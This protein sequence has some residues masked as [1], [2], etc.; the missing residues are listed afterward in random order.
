MNNIYGNWATLLLPLREDESID[1]LLLER[2]VSHLIGAKVNGIYSNGTAGEFYTLTPAE[3]ASTAE[4]LA[5]MCTA[6]GM[7]FQI[8]ASH[9]SAQTML[10]RIRIARQY[11]P[12]AIQVIL[13]DWLPVTN[14]EAVI[15]L[16]RAAET[17]GDI[18]LVV[19]NPPHA[20]RV[21]KPEDW[22]VLLDAVPQIAS[23][24]V[25]DGDEAWYEA[26]KP[27]LER[28]AVFVPGHHLATGFIRGAKGAYSNVAC[29][30]PVKAQRWYELMKTDPQAA[31][32][33]ERNVQAFM[34]AHISPLASR[35]GHHG[36]ALD[37]YMAT[38]GGWCDITPRIRFPY[39]SVP[40]TRLEEDRAALL[41]MAPY[42]ADDAISPDGRG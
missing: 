41:H 18:P 11:D 4:L 25:K 22:T 1:M 2:E 3:F 40:V 8:G 29:L 20:K 30:S 39:R 37:K 13:P 16:Q 34:A 19:Y 21:L 28:T 14:E 35:H 9:F 5:G 32:R 7:P 17:A 15:F 27:V 12:T 6:A 31:L 33:E 10:E 42:F 26:M 24:K 23:I 38:L 36:L